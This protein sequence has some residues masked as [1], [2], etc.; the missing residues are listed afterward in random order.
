MLSDSTHES[1]LS[2]NK[3]RKFI[4]VIKLLIGFGLIVFFFASG[5]LDFC[6]IFRSLAHIQFL[7]WGAF[8]CTLAIFTTV[9]RW[10]ILVCVQ[11][12]PLS[13]FDAIRLTMIG[14]FFNIFIPGGAGGDIIR[15]AYI[16]KDC[17]ERRAQALTVAFVDRGLGLHA[18]LFMG[19]LISVISPGIFSG[20]PGAHTWI[21]ILIGLF[22]IGTLSPF[23]M[24]S[25]HTSGPAIRFFG[26]FIGGSEAW[27]DAINCYRGQPIKISYAYLLSFANVVLNVLLLHFMMLAV[28]A[29]PKLIETLAFG[30]LVILANTLP[31]TPGG[32]GVAEGVS[33]GLYSL[34]GQS[35]GANGMLLA[36]FFIILGALPGLPFFLMKHRSQ[37]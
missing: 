30:P 19:L 9:L 7:I 25:K 34:I 23:I 1:I 22:V 28:G 21:V 4:S 15:A 37:N 14:Y 11:K 33:A 12:L 3:R 35:D 10:W 13:G 2:R 5:L 18:L 31:I 27:H 24:I 20:Y 36:R 29:N 6:V 26:R 8:C 32:I 17:P 16:V